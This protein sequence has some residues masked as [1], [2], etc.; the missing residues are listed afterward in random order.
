MFILLSCYTV[1]AQQIEDFNFNW[2][3]HL[4]DKENAQSSNFADK[5]WEQIRLPHDWSIL[6]PYNEEEGAGCT[7]YLV[8]G[9]GWYRKT[10]TVPES[11]KGKHIRIEFDGVYRNS[12]VWVNGQLLGKRPYGYIPFAYELDKHI[13]YGE[14]NIIAVKVDRSNVLDSRWYSGSGIYRNVRLVKSAQTRI[15]HWGLWVETPEITDGLAKVEVS[16][17]LKNALKA[18]KKIGLTYKIF[19]AQNKLVAEQKAKVA[20]DGQDTVKTILEVSNPQRWEIDSPKL[21]TVKVEVSQKGKKL[22]TYSQRFGIRKIEFDA[23]FGFKLNGK[24]TL[25]KGVCLHH[26]GGAVGAV[27]V[28]NVWTRRLKRLREIGVNAIRS[29]HNPMDPRLLELCDEMGFMVLNESFDEW[30][31]NKNK[32]KHIKRKA[33]HNELGYA[34]IFNDWGEQDVKDMVRYSRNHPSIIM[35]SIGNEIEWTYPYYWRMFKSHQQQ[36]LNNEVF[37]K[38]TGDGKDELKI[39]AEALCEWVKSIDTSRPTTT[40]GV[41]PDVGNFT[42]YYDVPDV[43]GYNYNVHKFGVDRNKY[44]NRMMYGSE[45][46]G[47]Y[48]E[49]KGVEDNPH[50]S[51]IFVWTGISYL[52]EAGPFPRKASSSSMFDLAGNIKPRGHL[53]KTLWKDEPHIYLATQKYQDAGWALDSL[54]NWQNKLPVK[55]RYKWTFENIEENWN[56]QSGDSVFVEVF[57][58]TPAVEL[59]VNGKSYGIKKVKDFEDR[60]VKYLVAYKAGEIKAVG[61]GIEESKTPSFS[62]KTTG[63][64]TKVKLQADQKSLTADAYSAVNIE[65]QLFDDN[66]LAVT[67][68]DTE[69][70]F[71]IEGVGRLLGTDNGYE[72][73][74]TSHQ[75]KTLSTHYGKALAIIQSNLEEGD[76]KVR[77]KVGNF[78]SDWVI[79]PVKK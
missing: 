64:P 55:S 18:K 15:A 57:A 27:F 52:G 62:L 21:Y 10:F 17:V 53:F 32:W 4:G 65:A 25:F 77:A 26:D 9:I 43:M 49:W 79:I 78:Y 14:E 30:K 7:A 19:D 29:A 31:R 38:E 50:A 59:F 5:D 13:K 75:S 39:T 73:S 20:V 72:S 33:K 67:A 60:Y 48:F 69:I 28:K 35:W 63:E 8:G 37:Y 2:K 23:E 44:P 54:G 47:T 1:S 6:Q 16:T 42:K 12:E 24:K 3:F 70:T 56:Y 68:M 76:I 45:N 11:D 71:E 34:T 66:N 61:R 46:W 51:G 22:N 41:L 40:G 36:G 58:N 74:V